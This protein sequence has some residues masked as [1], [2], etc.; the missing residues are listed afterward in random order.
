LRLTCNELFKRCKTLRESYAPVCA[1]ARK[2]EDDRV[3]N[4]STLMCS[5]GGSQHVVQR[6]L[7]LGLNVGHKR[8]VDCIQHDWDVPEHEQMSVIS[9][10]S[11]E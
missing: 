5:F 11:Y 9:E 7:S 1:G 2:C 10:S 8:G 6:R 3:T 4:V